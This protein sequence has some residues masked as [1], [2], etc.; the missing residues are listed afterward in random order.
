MKDIIIDGGLYCVVFD[1]HKG[2]LVLNSYVEFDSKL[3]LM[4][5]DLKKLMHFSLPIGCAR[6]RH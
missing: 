5:N 3:K 2:H 6:K 1:V 4:D